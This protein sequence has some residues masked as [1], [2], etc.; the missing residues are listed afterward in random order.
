MFSKL[1]S[2]SSITFCNIVKTFEAGNPGLWL[3]REERNLV[4]KFLFLV[5][6]ANDREPLYAYMKEK[7][8]VRPVDG[9]CANLETVLELQTDAQDA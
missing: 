8:F 6:S 3:T 4:R 5:K 9:S 7:G 1:K 2:Q